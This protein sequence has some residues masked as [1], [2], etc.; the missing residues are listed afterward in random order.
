M[1]LEKIIIIL[2]YITLT[3]EQE[4][5]DECFNISRNKSGVCLYLKD[6]DSILREI[7]IRR[8]FPS[9]QEHCGFDRNEPIV[10]CPQEEAT[11]R[12]ETTTIKTETTTQP[13]EITTQQITVN[14]TQ[15]IYHFGKNKCF[16]YSKRLK[17]VIDPENEFRII[18]G[19]N[20]SKGEFPH[21]AALGYGDI[22]EIKWN[23]G[24]TLINDFFV[25][26]AAHCLTSTEYG[27]VKFIQLGNI[28][29]L[30][31]IN[32]LRYHKIY[33]ITQVYKHPN[34]TPPSN[35]NDIAL[36]R[37][38]RKVDFT[39][40]IKPAC[41]YNEFN[42]DKIKKLKIEATGWGLTNFGGARSDFLL[43]VKLDLF[44]DTTCVETYR[45]NI[46]RRLPQGIVASQF[47]A[48][49]YNDSKD[50]CAGDSGGPLQIYNAT[51]GLY[52]VIGVTSFGK[53]CG[54]AG[55]P[56][57]YTKVS[58]YVPWIVETA[59]SDHDIF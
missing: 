26:T 3:Q 52:C 27:V 49:S 20:A 56:G 36:L 44:D 47:C 13:K 39:P 4:L 59:W 57:V 50:A 38:D 2:F 5:T 43:K 30:M 14:R 9:F 41:I 34:Y 1:F 42:F 17:N 53:T 37:V 24:G 12:P 28:S 58:F 54:Q 46:G 32:D 48:G 33:F 29:L 23:C 25:L 19:T 16:E 10:C 40:Y 11:K 21:M 15:I 51:G 55:V 35:Y 7:K 45:N 8:S 31:N 18:G 6:C 22:N